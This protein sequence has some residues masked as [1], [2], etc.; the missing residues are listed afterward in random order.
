MW[1]GISGGELNDPGHLWE[2][3]PRYRGSS[4]KRAFGLGTSLDAGLFFRSFLNKLW[5]M[6]QLHQHHL[7]ALWKWRFSGPTQNCWNR[8]WVIGLCPEG[9]MSMLKCTHP[10]HYYAQ[11]Q[12]L[13]SP[14]SRWQSSPGLRDCQHPDGIQGS[15]GVWSSALVYGLSDWLDPKSSWSRRLSRL[16]AIINSSVMFKK[17]K[18]CEGVFGHAD[19]YT[20]NMKDGGRWT[21]WALPGKHQQTQ[22]NNDRGVDGVDTLCRNKATCMQKKFLAPPHSLWDLSSLIRDQTHVFGNESTKS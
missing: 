11:T 15:R 14:D 18:R 13:S 20:G 10:C 5:S 3:K 6:D 12:I 19:K 21:Y 1:Q 9:F 16:K 4:G 8:I 17:N 7:G 22:I 2:A